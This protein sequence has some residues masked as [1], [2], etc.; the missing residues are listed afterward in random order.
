MTELDAPPSDEALSLDEPR[1][2]ATASLACVVAGDEI[3][4][5]KE[6]IARTS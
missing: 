6:G 1:R 5:V 2:H 4:F 3:G